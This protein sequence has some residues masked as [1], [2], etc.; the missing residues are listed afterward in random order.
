MGASRIGAC[1]FSESET[2]MKDPQSK[3]LRWWRQAQSDLQTAEILLAE[4]EF[5][6]CAFHAQQASEKA[7]KAMLYVRGL[8]PFGHSSTARLAHAGQ[9][10]FPSPTG[11]IEDAAT[12]LDTLHFSALS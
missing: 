6:A 5:S 4:G 3:S 7:L 10:G 1:E 12:G 2:E 9:E 8:R 11:E